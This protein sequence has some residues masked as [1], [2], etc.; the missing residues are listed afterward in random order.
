MDLTFFWIFGILMT[1]IIADLLMGKKASCDCKIITE[2][3]LFDKLFNRARNAVGAWIDNVDTTK[4]NK[5]TA[6]LGI[7][8]NG[9]A[10]MAFSCSHNYIE[11]YFIKKAQGMAAWNNKKLMESE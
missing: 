7:F 11:I 9:V 8:S 1:V 10:I 4:I 2:G 6:A 3:P 5:K